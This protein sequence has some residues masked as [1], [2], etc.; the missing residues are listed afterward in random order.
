MKSLGSPHGVTRG[1][2]GKSTQYCSYHK[3]EIL[4]GNRSPRCLRKCITSSHTRMYQSSSYHQ[5][6]PSQ[7]VFKYKILISNTI[8][9]WH[10]RLIILFFKCLDLWGHFT[11]E[12]SSIKINIVLLTKVFFGNGPF[13]GWILGNS[14]F[15]L[16]SLW[17]C[18]WDWN[19]SPWIFLCWS[20]SFS[21][22]LCV[23]YNIVQF[24]KI[25]LDFRHWFPCKW[26]WCQFSTPSQYTLGYFFLLSF[27]TSVEVKGVFETP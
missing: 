13:S 1:R 27:F 10:L 14:V 26:S 8:L 21:S 15:R 17:W 2:N 20:F 12:H 6:L 22:R 24:S 9:K 3:L 5:L 23:F 11:W 19:W 4:N 18:W 16:C 7:N 25:R